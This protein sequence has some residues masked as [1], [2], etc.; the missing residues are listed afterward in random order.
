MGIHPEIL[1]RA[2]ERNQPHAGAQRLACITTVH[3]LHACTNVYQHFFSTAPI[4]LNVVE[5]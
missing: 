3:R 1:F 2:R 4:V 5:L